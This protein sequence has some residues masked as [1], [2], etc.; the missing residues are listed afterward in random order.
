MKDKL[1][2]TLS[3]VLYGLIGLSVLVTILF[4]VGA[5]GEALILNW[6]YA[7]LGIAVVAAIVFPII[8]L[9]QDPKKAK[10]ALI[11]AV[12]LAI[13]FAVA[14]V[15]ASDAVLVSYEPY[16]VNESTSQYV[17][18]GII[19]TYLLMGLS[20]GGILFFGIMSIFKS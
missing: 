19:G 12:G 10:G 9:A 3:Y 11:S 20:G 4:Y 6:A 17:G 14:Y 8:V 15:L 7:L 1:A 16:G 13:V 18:M 2:K 5:I